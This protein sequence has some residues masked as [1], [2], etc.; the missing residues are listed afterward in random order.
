MPK[1]RLQNKR[2]VIPLAALYT[3]MNDKSGTEV[4]DKSFLVSCRTCRSIINP[5]VQIVNNTQLWNCQFCGTSNQL[6]PTFNAQGE[7]VLHPSLNPGSTT[8]EYQTGR[9]SSLPPVFFYVVDTCFEGD[10]VE[11]AF[12]Q[13]KESLIISLSL[14]PED[15]L[16]GLIT[17]GKHVSVH[18]LT[19]NDNI[20]HTF[21]G[22]KT[23]TLEKVQSSLG[24]LG[25]ELSAAG[26]KHATQNGSQLPIGNAARR[27][28]QPLNLVEYQLTSILENLV[29][30]SFPRN[31]FS[32]RPE[33]CTGSAINV[34]ALLLKSIFGDA[35]L[36]G[37]HL[38]VFMSGV[39]TLGPGK[40]VDKHLKTPLRSHH[41]IIKSQSVSIP[42]ATSTSKISKFDVSL[43]K[44]CK[45]FYHG[46][47]K[48]LIGLGLS[49]DLFIGSYDQVGLF[50][51]DEVCYKTGGAVVMSDSF[52]TAIFKQSFIKFFKKKEGE[53]EQEQEQ[54][55]GF[56]L[57]DMAFNATLEVKAATDIKVE[58]LIGQATSLPIN[59][60]TPANARMVAET[61]VGEGK[62]NSWK[63]CSLNP[64][65]TFAIYL[66]KLDS[67]TTQTTYIQFLLHYQH[68][69]GE[70]RL[71]V[72]TVP[73]NV[74]PD[75]DN[76]NLEFGFDQEAALVLVARKAIEKLRIDS[77]H[78]KFATSAAIIKELDEEMIS[79]CSRF[80]V[81]TQGMPDSFRLS[82]A[83]SLFPQF[84]YHLRRSPFINVFNSSPDETSYVRTLFMH[85]D[86]ANSLLMIQPS[87]LSYDINTWG[88]STDG[89][90]LLEQEQEPKPVLLDSASLGHSK[91]L[92]LDTFFHILIH[93]GSQVADWRNAGY[94]EQEEYAHFRDFLEAPKREAL[95]ILSERFP[96]PRFINCDEGGSQARF[97]MAKLNPSTSYATNVNH[98]YGTGDRMDVFTDDVSLQLYMDH[99]QRIITSKK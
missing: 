80:G 84:I 21:S 16:V 8:I 19:S 27:F 9:H 60:T 34:A 35:H 88:S 62:T 66:D 15:A 79:F 43:L 76:V 77:I 29:C 33:R 96:L 50:E 52:A 99:V 4:V 87:L 25:S 97:L 11:S 92:L 89:N 47:T 71:R 90:D 41:D 65:S 18:D 57:L 20:S 63:L 55:Q 83:Y 22:S 69:T 49:C 13:L 5:Y 12:E 38:M 64:K 67:M 40:V 30:N 1:S 68:P 82:S 93:H 59:K 45:M 91:I 81:F 51:M 24:I 46:I 26:L 3:P 37:G 75:S 42:S 94:H 2:N 95:E 23:Y 39:C 73:I 72:T 32:E 48:L 86:L 85:E 98:F 44:E 58:G 74:L 31:N 56:G 6:P 54:E 78:K 7:P 17:F 14:L 61:D 28:V 36:T 53:Q 70:I 10:D